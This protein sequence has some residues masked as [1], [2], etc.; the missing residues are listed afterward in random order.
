M[1]II[2]HKFRNQQLVQSFA[3]PLPGLRRNMH[4]KEEYMPLFRSNNISGREVFIG[5][6]RETHRWDLDGF[7]EVEPMFSFRYFTLLIGKKY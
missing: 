4:H 5:N 6:P 3:R 2:Y 7:W 1:K